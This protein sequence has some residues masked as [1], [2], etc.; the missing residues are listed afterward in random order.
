MRSLKICTLFLLFLSTYELK[1]RYRPNEEKDS[2]LQIKNR[3]ETIQSHNNIGYCL[4]KTVLIELLEGKVH[5]LFMQWMFRFNRVYFKDNKQQN[6]QTCILR[7]AAPL[8]VQASH[9]KKNRSSVKVCAKVLKALARD[10][11]LF[12]SKDYCLLTREIL[13]LGAFFIEA[14]SLE[15]C[16]ALLRLL[17]ERNFHDAWLLLK[18]KRDIT[19]VL[20]FAATKYIITPY[21]VQ[22]DKCL[23]AEQEGNIISTLIDATIIWVL[24]DFC[25]YVLYEG[26]LSPLRTKGLSYNR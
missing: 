12:N 3:Y 23:S 4:I 13:A 10:Y 11:P 16:E 25:E 9:S 6:I 14:F 1:A 18:E 26:I 5:R 8:L 22:H 15:K 2:T 24:F 20:T 21:F 17:L 19:H 7:E